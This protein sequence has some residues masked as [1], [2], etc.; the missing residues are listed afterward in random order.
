[1]VNA[2]RTIANIPQAMARVRAALAMTPG[3]ETLRDSG[4]GWQSSRAMRSANE[5]PLAAI[6][7]LTWA[8]RHDSNSARARAYVSTSPLADTAMSSQHNSRSMRM[9][10]DTHHTAG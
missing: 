6:D 4:R 7:A 10:A 3:P 5:L 1:M 9:C 2:E 8:G